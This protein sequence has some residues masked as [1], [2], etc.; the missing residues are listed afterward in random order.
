MMLL[1]G[2]RILNNRGA[3]NRPAQQVESSERSFAAYNGNFR[4]A[5]TTNNPQYIGCN[6][7]GDITHARKT[8]QRSRSPRGE[9][10]AVSS[11]AKAMQNA[12]PLVE[13]QFALN[14]KSAL[15]YVFP[16][17]Q[18]TPEQYS[19]ISSDLAKCAHRVYTEEVYQEE[20]SSFSQPS[21]T[22]TSGNSAKVP[23]PL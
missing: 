13:R 1:A 7:L 19:R 9:A 18:A 6:I 12:L 22:P 23:P 15:L 14:T 8:R 16:D 20:L 3:R 10:L 17:L 2:R 4:N 5:V 21:A 11:Y